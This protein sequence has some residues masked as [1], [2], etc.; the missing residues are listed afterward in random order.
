MRRLAGEQ[1]PLSQWISQNCLIDSW[2]RLIYED[3]VLLT[4][5]DGMAIPL[6]WRQAGGWMRILGQ[7]REE[8]KKPSTMVQG[9]RGRI[10]CF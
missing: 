6:S 2:Q 9:S 4:R 8:L 3:N 1:L 10:L 7:I 5:L